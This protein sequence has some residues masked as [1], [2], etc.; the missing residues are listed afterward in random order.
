MS[1]AR[2]RSLTHT[3]GD[4]TPEERRAWIDAVLCLQKAPSKLDRTL[5]PGAVSRYDD[6][7]VVHMNQ[8]M[9]IHGTVR[10][11]SRDY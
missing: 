5:Y 3:R 6:F 7:V 9:S 4:I 10:R 2:I 1:L 11:L 8:T